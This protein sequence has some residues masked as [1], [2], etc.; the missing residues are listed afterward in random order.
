[1]MGQ[2]EEARAQPQPQGDPSFEDL[3]EIFAALLDRLPGGDDASK[4]WNR[5]AVLALLDRLVLCSGESR[6]DVLGEHS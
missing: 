4:A 1:M 2:K 5:G 3:D 6:L